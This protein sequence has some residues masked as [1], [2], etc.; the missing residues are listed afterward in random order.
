MAR[1]YCYKV[2]CDVNLETFQILNQLKQYKIVKSKFI[3]NAIEK[4]I[5]DELPKLKVKR[6][7]KQC[8]F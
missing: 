5:K 8:P 4:A 7:Y 1:I 3:R 6:T 2:N